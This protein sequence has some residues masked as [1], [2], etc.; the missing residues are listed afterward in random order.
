[1]RCCRFPEEDR[2]TSN[3]QAFRCL[4]VALTVGNKEIGKIVER[5]SLMK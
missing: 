1:M 2:Q 4:G 3:Y 5:P